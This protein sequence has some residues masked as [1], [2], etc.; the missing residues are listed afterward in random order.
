MP[1]SELDIIMRN[2]ITFCNRLKKE[3]FRIKKGKEKVLYNYLL[4]IS[5]N[6]QSL[7]SHLA[8]V[9]RK[10]AFCLMSMYLMYAGF[11]WFL[12]IFLRIHK[13]NPKAYHRT[14]L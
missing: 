4:C 10:K 6:L 9:L 5:C 13:P 12:M 3:N 1:P 8:S 2:F 11:I 7:S 14:A